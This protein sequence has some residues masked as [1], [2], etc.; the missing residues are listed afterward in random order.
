MDFPPLTGPSPGQRPR[1]VYV[2]WFLWRISGSDERLARIPA[3]Q[4][5]SV[6]VRRGGILEAQ[7]QLCNEAHRRKENEP[8]AGALGNESCCGVVFFAQLSHYHFTELDVRSS[9]E[10]KEEHKEA[11]EEVA[12]AA[13][14]AA[15]APK[16]LFVYWRR[17][18]WDPLELPKPFA[19]RRG[20]GSILLAFSPGAPANIEL[21]P[22]VPT[23]EARNPHNCPKWLREGAEGV[24]A[25]WRK[26]LP[27]L[28]CTTTTLFGTNAT[29]FCTSA[30]GLWSPYTKT[31]FA[32]SPNH[33][34]QF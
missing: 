12:A 22:Q 28:S 10:Q 26:G 29:L 3:R 13:A 20:F 32:P 31:P 4:D 15:A 2:E 5:N 1:N 30:T 8:A 23:T 6:V 19:L 7:S 21:R 16:L 18:Q 24:L 27:R 17:L 11:I 33:F 9:I 34:G 25:S 14:A